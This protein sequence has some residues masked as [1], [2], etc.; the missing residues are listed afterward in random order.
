MSPSRCGRMR[1][2]GDHATQRTPRVQRAFRPAVR[3]AIAALGKDM[4]VQGAG[5]FRHITGQG[6]LCERGGIQRVRWGEGRTCAPWC[7]SCRIVAVVTQALPTVLLV[8]CAKC[9]RSVLVCCPVA[10]SLSPCSLLRCLS[11]RGCIA[12][13]ALSAHMCWQAV[14]NWSLTCVPTDSESCP[15][16]VWQDS[17][18]ML[19]C[20]RSAEESLSS[21]TTAGRVSD[22]VRWSR[23]ARE[24][25]GPWLSMHSCCCAQCI[26]VPD[27]R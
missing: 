18:S 8:A 13:L 2:A 6:G 20:T 22:P 5:V 21:L 1:T 19:C 24:P 14:P 17:C 15:G 16:R 11:L 23:Q 25:S 26:A 10:Q 9:V 4:P 27:G 3:G 7:R 12:P